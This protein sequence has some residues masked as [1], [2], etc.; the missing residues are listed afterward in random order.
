MNSK[1]HEAQSTR[2]EVPSILL[3][4]PQLG[5][6]I[7]AAARAMM[8]FGLSDLRITAPK[9]GWPNERAYDMAGKAAPILDALKTYDDTASAMADL[10]YAYAMTARSRELQKPVME[11]EAAAR[12]MHQRLARGERIGIL[13]G[14]ERTGLENEDIVRCDAIITIPTAPD[15]T[16]LNIAQ[17]VVVMAYEWHRHKLLRAQQ[18]EPA[19]SPRSGASLRGQE[20]E[21]EANQKTATK[22]ELEGFF[23]HLESELDAIDFWKNPDKKPIMWQNLRTAF[24]RATLTEQEVRTLRGVVRELRSRRG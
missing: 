19:L 11:P 3:I 2:H 21:Q 13:Y 23:T 8:N 9:N 14:P 1:K 5:E 7:G 6:N 10:N 24:I 4:R 17:S 18:R 20:A 22:A 12:D 16:S 15:H